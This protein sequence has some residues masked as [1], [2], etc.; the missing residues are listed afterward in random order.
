MRTSHRE[1]RKRILEEKSKI[2]DEEF[3]TSKAYRGYLTDL[4]EAATRRYNRPL[5]VT[6]VADH[7]N[8]QLA[9]TDFNGIFIN[10]CNE[11][12][13]SMPSRRLRSLSIEGLVAHENG[14]N[15]FTDNRIW[16]SF[17]K[18]LEQGKFYPN[19]PTGL[20][21]MQKLRAK[22][23][24]DAMQD[25]T[26]DIPRMVINSTAK[27]LSNILEDGYVDARYSY[28]FPG[29]PARGIALNNL[30][31]NEK[32][33]DIESMVNKKYCDHNIEK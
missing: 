25:D 3:F 1:I 24:L 28:E 14:H 2:S 10:A 23:I 21:A 17:H 32:A 27:A 8:D 22:E 16:M 11:I 19:M 20:D 13:W 29:N 9:F 6:I 7:D 30:R 4:A 12:T 5:R 31:I 26:D 18:K 15:L 33:P